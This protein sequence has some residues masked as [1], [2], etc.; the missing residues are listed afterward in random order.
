MAL[1][2]A[3]IGEVIAMPAPEILT[4]AKIK[5]PDS[6]ITGPTIDY[7][8]TDKPPPATPEMAGRG[9][10]PGFIIK[11]GLFVRIPVGLCILESDIFIVRV[12]GYRKA[13][14]SGLFTVTA[15]IT[16]A[17]AHTPVKVTVLVEESHRK[18]LAFVRCPSA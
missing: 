5:H 10:D 1:L 9:L 18:R 16:P 13:D 8:R 15:P 2:R 6:A 14:A 4:T 7:Q 11:L 3:F 12:R 17:P